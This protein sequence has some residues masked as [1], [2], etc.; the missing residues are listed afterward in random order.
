M[1]HGYGCS[2]S[3]SVNALPL[4]SG[5]R[6]ASCLGACCA[7]EG[8]YC[9]TRA[10]EMGS[11]EK[12]RVAMLKSSMAVFLAACVEAPL[13]TTEHIPGIFPSLAKELSRLFA[14]GL[15]LLYVG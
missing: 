8:G 14:V 15:A 10:G 9:L 3:I 7:K 4:S 11:L 12:T 5:L 6:A 13:S 1:M 2:D